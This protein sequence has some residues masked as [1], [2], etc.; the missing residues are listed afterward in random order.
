MV[1]KANWAD[2]LLDWQAGR[3]YEEYDGNVSEI[4]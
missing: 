3:Q 4:G 1:E 2:V